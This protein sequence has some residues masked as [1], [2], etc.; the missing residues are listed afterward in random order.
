[1]KKKVLIIVAVVLLIVAGCT[2]AF[3][4]QNHKSEKTSVANANNGAE[5]LQGKEAD[6][7]QADAEIK[8]T[9]EKTTET[10]VKDEK[11]T[12][13]TE[14]GRTTESTTTE[15]VASSAGFTAPAVTETPTVSEKP[16]TT[17][18][19]APTTKPNMTEAPATTEKPST[20]EAAPAH[21][22]KWKT[23]EHKAETHK[24]K[25]L[26][27]EA[28]DEDVYEYH[29]YCNACGT[30]LENMSDEELTGHAYDCSSG[31]TGGTI[32]V[33]TV[34]HDAEYETVTVVDKEAW[35]ETVCETCG[36]RK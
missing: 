30:Y 4:V 24:E 2:A 9:S 20:T 8:T 31:Y 27:H 33:G 6:D 19:Q 5:T 3:I 14:T 1:M 35:T 32:K 13:T 21:V 15:S 18:V 7:K 12:K 25:Q 23:I 10:S 34:H 17:E 11:D 29:V 26:V 36:E 16:K 28:Y 22:H